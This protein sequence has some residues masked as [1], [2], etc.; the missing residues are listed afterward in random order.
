[1]DVS[2]WIE[3]IITGPG[4]ME[5]YEHHEVVSWNVPDRQAA[6]G[7]ALRCLANP[8]CEGSAQVLA[9]IQERRV[10]AELAPKAGPICLA[11]STT[12]DG[13]F[14]VED[15]PGPFCSACWQKL[16]EH[17]AEARSEDSASRCESGLPD[18]GPAPASLISTTNWKPS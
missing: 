13:G 12:G 1:M 14:E 18:C 5:A 3:R 4:G 2:A 8:Q 7:W 11:C 9:A 15:G 6:I 10:E 16:E 17:F